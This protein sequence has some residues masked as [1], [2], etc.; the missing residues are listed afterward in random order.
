MMGPGDTGIPDERLVA[1]ARD[2]NDA[3]FEELIRRHKRRILGMAARFARDDLELEEIAQEAF[4]KA[5]ENL[6]R[7]RGDAPFAHWLAR[8]ASNT[9]YDFLRKRKRRQAELPVELFEHALGAPEETARPDAEDLA[10]LA[11]A[12]EKLKPEERLVLTLM[13]LEEKSVKETAYIMGISEGNVKVRAHRARKALKQLMEKEQ[14][15]G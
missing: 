3:A 15:H 5:Y 11:R 1:M 10:A 6:V 12:M 9:C 7:F 13:E 2:G 4:V 14:D 8:I